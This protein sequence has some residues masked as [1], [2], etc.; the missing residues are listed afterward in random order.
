ME[1]KRPACVSAIVTAY[2]QIPATLKTLEE[3]IK[4]IPPPEEILVHVDGNQVACAKAIEAAYP[5]VQVILSEQNVGPGG[6]R[7]RLLAAARCAY[8]ASFDDDSY[9]LQVD[10]FQRIPE[11]FARYPSASIVAAS[12]LHRGESLPATATTGC[13]WVAAF[14]G[15]GCVYR[16]EEFVKTAGYV[17]LA[18]AYGMEEVDLALRIIDSGGRILWVPSLRVF[19]DTDRSHHADPRITAFSIANIALL[20]FL[21]YP[22]LYWPVGIAQLFRRVSWL[23]R[24]RRL[25]GIVDGFLMSPRHLFEHRG[26]RAA[27]SARSLRRIL[28]LRRKPEPV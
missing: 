17:P 3:L 5:S 7:N 10:Y 23:V 25:G 22:V 4:C 1:C 11:L 24:A 14:G 21:R 18:V 28:S 2:K 16:R 26:Y 6:G 12:I 27:I 19:H 20:V 8:V 9:P 13:A 15:G